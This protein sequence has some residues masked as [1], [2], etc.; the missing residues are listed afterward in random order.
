[1]KLQPLFGRASAI[2]ISRISSLV[3]SF[4]TIQYKTLCAAAKLQKFVCE[5]TDNMSI[6]CFLGGKKIRKICCCLSYS[7]PSLYCKLHVSVISLG[8]WDITE[9]DLIQKLQL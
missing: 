4:Q 8:V 9:A 6:E 5:E 2:E 3:T 1:M 7:H